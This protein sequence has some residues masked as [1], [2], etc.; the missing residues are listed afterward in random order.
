[1]VM[2]TNEC[3]YKVHDFLPSNNFQYIQKDPTNKYQIY[4]T[5]A[6]QNS[7]LIIHRNQIKHFIQRKP[8]PSSLIAQIKIHNPD[9]L[10]RPS[11]NNIHAQAYKIPKFMPKN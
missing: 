10:I 1:V 7:S 3:S 8:R 6:L 4:I 9:D 2:Y 11:V 5:K